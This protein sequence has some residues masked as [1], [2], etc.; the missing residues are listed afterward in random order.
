[1]NGTSWL[2]V[3]TRSSLDRPRFTSMATTLHKRSEALSHAT[4]HRGR[5]QALRSSG[6]TAG[7]TTIVPPA[8]IRHPLAGRWIRASDL[9]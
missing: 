3:K 9:S 2:E 7:D 8:A 5:K 6:V 4:I 1:M